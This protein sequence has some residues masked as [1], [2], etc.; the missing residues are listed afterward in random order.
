MNRITGN[1]VDIEN[2]TIFFGSVL[3]S[4]NKIVG[5]ERFSEEK[6][7][8]K[9]ILPGFVDSHIHIESSMLVPSEFARVAVK[10]GVIATVSDPHEIAN[11][12]GKKG[13]DYMVAN[14]KL[15]DFK[16]FFG[17]PSCVPA[18]PFDRAGAVLNVSDVKE[19]LASGQFYYLSEMM[20]Y[21]GVIYN[22]AEVMSKINSALELGYKIDGHAPGIVDES[23]KK[24]VDAGISTDHECMSV[25]EAETKIKLGMKVL[26]REGSAAKNFDS[27]IEI[28]KKY[29]SEIMFCS[30]DCHPDDLLNQYFVN[31]IRR[32]IAAGVD[33]IDAIK[34]AG[35]NAVKHYNLPVGLLKTDDYADF[36]MVDN[37]TD[38]NVQQTYI[39]GRLIYNDGKSL[40]EKVKVDDINNF[41]QNFISKNDIT[42]A[43]ID[44]SKVEVKVIDTLEGELYTKSLIA[45]LPVVD[46]ALVSDVDRDILKIVV[47]NRY[48][49]AK[50]AVGF[51]RGFGLKQGAICS[52]IAHDSH[53][54]VAVGTDDES[55]V[56]VVNAV[57]EAKGGMAYADNEAV[58]I[59]N[60]PVAGIMS[61]KS[62]EEVAASYRELLDFTRKS[63]SSMK[64]PFMTMAFMSLVV[65]P[66]LKISDT[67]LFDV[68]KFEPTSLFANGR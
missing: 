59:L 35:Y 5:I 46:G 25:L 65:I 41:Y 17:V 66:E 55:I 8:Q 44:N 19:M 2:R 31:L 48:Q 1:I 49:K 28:A 30:D 26:I 12:L 45:S 52:S 9:Y 57:V 13:V 43:S 21:P 63:G 53:N 60:L 6:P 20:N 11:V 24:Y 29:P 68:V 38:F 32:A 56:K 54:I 40:I 16:F 37:L 67:G 23:L 62:A 36:V 3:Y 51:I 42:I 15:V 47:L 64:A 14:G 33:V 22:D 39:N 4:D 58:K 10:T 27:L 18:T 61:D 34:M 50:P 7:G